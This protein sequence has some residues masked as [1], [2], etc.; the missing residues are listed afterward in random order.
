[1]AF[2]LLSLCAHAKDWLVD[3]T[4]YKARIQVL[5]E[6]KE[7]LLSNGLIQRRMVLAPNAATVE[8]RNLRTGQAILR[9]IKPEASIQIDGKTY[10]VGGLIGQPN[11]AFLDPAWIPNLKNDPGAFEF[12][13]YEIREKLTER[14]AWKPTRHHAPDAVLAAQGY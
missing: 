11:Y 4:P 10:A 14:M 7:L 1:M 9:G 5:A 8:F 6:D 13:G 12:E 2:G 3:P